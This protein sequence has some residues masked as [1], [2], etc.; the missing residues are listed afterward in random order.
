MQ[1]RKEIDG[2]RALAVLPVILFHAGFETF[3]GGF[4]GVDVFF[5]ISGYLITSI[6][7]AELEQDRFSLVNFYER[8]ARRILPALFIVI[9]VCVPFAWAWLLPADM[10][11]FAQSVAA[12]SVFASNF[13]FWRESGYFDTAAELKPLLHTWSLSVEEQ[14]Y[15][16]FPLFLLLTWRLGKRW[17]LALLGAVF[18]TSLAV[19]QWASLEKPA[20][21]FYLLPTR[22]WELLLGAF[23]AFYLA[24]AHRTGFRR[25][26]CEAGGWLG[27]ALIFYAV[28]AYSKTTPFPGLYALVPTLGALLVIVFATQKTSVGRFVGNR[29][30]V[31]IGLL[32]YSAYLWHQPLF[33]FYRHAGFEVSP[34]SSF[35]L[36]ACV[37]AAAYFTWTYVEQPFRKKSLGGRRFIFSS[38]VVAA[39]CLFLFGALGHESDGYST[40]ASMSVFQDLTYDTSRL[41]YASCDSEF[42]KA[43]PALN[44]CMSGGEVANA[45][46]VGDSHA[47]DKFYGIEKSVGQYRWGLLGNSSCPPLIGVEIRSPDGMD[48]TER[49]KKLFKY[50]DES[51]EVELVVLS[52]AHMYPLD[53]YIAADHLQRGFDPKNSILVDMFDSS[54]GKVDAFYSGLQRTLEFFDKRGIRA[55]LVLDIPELGFFPSACLRGKGG[56][57]FQKNEVLSRQ[58]IL[59]ERVLELAARGSV[60]VFDSLEVFCAPGKDVC[61][62]MREGRSLYR[63]SHHLTHFGSLKFG[64]EFARWFSSTVR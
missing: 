43:A 8:R 10:K 14:Y 26:V 50:I 32:S 35:F 54:L 55:V 38:S 59:R 20:A 49:L 64:E 11:D 23:A 12:I 37:F 51:K 3:G 22:G 56:C 60:D 33:A 62:I 48:C 16:L 41:G 15:L 39:A 21:A 4:V 58:V 45:L 36:I 31:G 57:E 52:F 7:I 9:L 19:A 42:I 34:S 63:D 40:R 28:F 29:A 27:V 46:V 5:V 44:Y 6:I 18:F 1:Y 2:L 24:R 47:D 53:D 13:L 61:S 30:F 17:V 25:G